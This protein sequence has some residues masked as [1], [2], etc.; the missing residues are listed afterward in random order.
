MLPHYLWQDL[1]DVAVTGQQPDATFS[2]GVVCTL[3]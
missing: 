2:A 1:Q 3:L